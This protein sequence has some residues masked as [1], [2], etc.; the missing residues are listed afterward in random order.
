MDDRIARLMKAMVEYDRGDNPRIHHFLKVHNLAKT[1]GCLEGV[2]NDTMQVLEAAA[3]VHDI[4]IHISEMK[5]GSS[6]GKYQEVE[7][8]P[9][10][11]LLM[12]R[13]GGFSNDEIDRVAFLVGHHHTY[14]NID[15]IDYQI[16]VEADFL[17][18]IFEDGLTPEAIAEVRRKIFRT[19]AGR[20][21]LDAMYGDAPWKTAPQTEKCP[22]CC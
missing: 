4:G 9:E 17:V 12:R 13:V 11:R 6:K 20:E 3:I 10:A 15:G 21:L 14:R 5:Y 7:G 19:K 2:D 16:L 18:N 8:P 1:I 22:S